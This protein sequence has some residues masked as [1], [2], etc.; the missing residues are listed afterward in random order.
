MSA[1]SD[2][3]LKIWNID[4][5]TCTSTLKPHKDYVQALSYA[6]YTES[7]VS[8]GL[9]QTLY[10]WDITSLTQLTASKNTVTSKYKY[11]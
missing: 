6:S 4:R 11:Y 2:T 8:A 1:S 3:S 10:L 9:D 7:I 5:G